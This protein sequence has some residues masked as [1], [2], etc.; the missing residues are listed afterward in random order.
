MLGFFE[1]YLKHFALNFG[2]A[3][4]GVRYFF[5]HPDIDAAAPRGTIRHAALSAGL[6]SKRVVN[7]L[8]FAL[9]PPHWHHTREELSSMKRIP[10]LRWFQYGY[11]AWRF[12]GSGEVKQELAGV[13][14]RWDPR[15]QR[16]APENP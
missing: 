14:R 10:T 13:D 1:E 8:C 9:I 16:P 5:S 6:R 11:C 12:T 7:D 15:C 3:L 4:Q 2:Q